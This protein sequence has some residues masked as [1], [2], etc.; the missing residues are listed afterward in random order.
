MAI[1][2]DTTTAWRVA[3]RFDATGQF[4]EFT[5]EQPI[6]SVDV[7]QPIDGSTG[8]HPTGGSRPST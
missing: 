7:V 4:I 6:D 5:A 8:P 1:D 2:G 3:D